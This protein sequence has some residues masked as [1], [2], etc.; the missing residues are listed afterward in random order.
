MGINTGSPLAKY[1][2]K[3]IKGWDPA[4][5]FGTPNFEALKAIV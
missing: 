4:T 1:G 2:F 5:G 3:A